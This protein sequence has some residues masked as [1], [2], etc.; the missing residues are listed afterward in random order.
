MNV[1]EKY[2]DAKISAVIR[3][4]DKDCSLRVAT[5][6]GRRIGSW[7]H[8]FA[9]FHCFVAQTKENYPNGERAQRTKNQV[10]PKHFFA[11]G[12]YAEQPTATFS[13]SGGIA[14][15]CRPHTRDVGT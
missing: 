8:R 10:H 13:G 9:T 7:R 1:I 15:I 11:N 12:T 2:K 6:L 3:T 5:Y 4:D 14:R